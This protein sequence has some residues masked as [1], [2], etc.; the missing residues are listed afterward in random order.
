MFGTAEYLIFG[1]IRVDSVDTCQSGT[2][3]VGLKNK[4]IKSVVADQSTGAFRRRSTTIL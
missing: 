3:P 2:R 4:C 1:S